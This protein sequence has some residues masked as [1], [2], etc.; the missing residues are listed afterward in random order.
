M[1]RHPESPRR[2][3]LAITALVRIILSST[4]IVLT[5]VFVSC[6]STKEIKKEEAPPP[7]PV[8]KPLV[9]E[10]IIQVASL[11]LSK[12]SG[13]IGKDDVQK[14]SDIIRKFKIDILALQGITRY[15]ELKTRIDA[16]DELANQ[17]GMRHA[18]GENITVNGRQVGNAIF[19]NYPM[20][21]DTSTQFTGLLSANFESELQAIIDC[22]VRDVIVVSA[23]LPEN[24][25]MTDQVA[26]VNQLS[27]LNEF[28]IDTPIIV[29][30]NLPRTD[31]VKQFARY[32]EARINGKAL[33]LWY[34]RGGLLKSL[35]VQ[36]ENSD[37]GTL[38]ITEFGIF[39]KSQP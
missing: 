26:C 38:I 33:Y 4:L 25:G 28:Y 2:A 27:A 5:L 17:T 8:K 9:P 10:I 22:G 19:S 24:T 3:G 15:P 21:S 14:L 34:S 31:E 29:T 32:S 37:L 30:G 16:V 11:D 23:N 12:H 7:A 36:V 39:R 20:K 6:S 13:R 35:N 1:I 18:F